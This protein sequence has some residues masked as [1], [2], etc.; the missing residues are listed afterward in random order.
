[1][2]KNFETGKTQTELQRLARITKVIYINVA[3]I[4]AMNYSDADQIVQLS[5]LHD[6]LC[7]QKLYIPVNNFSVI[8]G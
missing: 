4:K 8:S 7:C 6:F 1:M 5:I 3:I 2:D